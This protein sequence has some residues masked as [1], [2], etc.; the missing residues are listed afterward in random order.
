MD[1]KRRDAKGQHADFGMARRYLRMAICLMR[2]DQTY[3]PKNLR[4]AKND[5]KERAEYYITSWS[6]LHAKWKRSGALDIA[7]DKNM[8]LGQWRNMIQE[9]YGIEL[10]L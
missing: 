4:S 5:M 6:T 9:L 8:R 1:Y 7:F 10:T 3:L 2:T